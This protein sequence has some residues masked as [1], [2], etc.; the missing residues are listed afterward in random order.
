MDW[1]IVGLWVGII[2]TFLL[3]LFNFLWGGGVISLRN[4]VRIRAPV[5]ETHLI[6]FRRDIKPYLDFSCKFKLVRSRGE[7][8]LYF[9]G[10][11]IKCKKV[12]ISK[13]EN[14]FILPGNEIFGSITYDG[15]ELGHNKRVS[16]K[17]NEPVEFVINDHFW[18]QD[19]LIKIL[20]KE[21]R[22]RNAT[23]SPQIMND[24]YE[25]ANKYIVVWQDGRGKE[26]Q[27]RVPDKLWYRILPDC[28]WWNI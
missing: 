13:L 24:L 2:I 21:E 11:Y 7:K 5:I 9:E 26:W 1:G 8:D 15:K 28:I 20:E 6:V 4:V 23:Q 14:Y 19:S 10:V 17:V 16:L 22:E 12:I 3:G 18:I 25:L 27:Y